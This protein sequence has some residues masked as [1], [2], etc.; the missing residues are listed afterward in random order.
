MR[1]NVLLFDED[2]DLPPAPA[3]PPEPEVIEPVFSA[4]EL[5]AARAEVAQAAH[6]AALAAFETAA[7]FAA[8]RALD[9]IAAEIAAAREDF[10]RAAEQSA[11]GIARLL[12]DCFAAAFPALSTRHGPGEIAAVLREVLPALRHEP[13]VVVRLSPHIAAGMTAE[14]ER[15]DPDFVAHVRVVPTDA[16][17]AGDVRIAW[18][19]GGAIRDTAAIWARIESIL[20]PMGLLSP[21]Q[22]TKEHAYVD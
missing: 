14:I 19:N 20:A 1:A 4:A 17:G 10:A 15:M 13:K 11:D 9:T 18:E 3:A 2:F 21:R 12:L 5:E 7:A 8:R 22:T 16:V 6:D